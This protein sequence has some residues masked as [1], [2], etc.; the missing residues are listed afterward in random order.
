MFPQCEEDTRKWPQSGD[1]LGI[2]NQVY[3]TNTISCCIKDNHKTK[4]YTSAYEV[5]LYN[6]EIKLGT[7]RDGTLKLGTALIMNKD[8]NHHLHKIL[9][10][11]FLTANET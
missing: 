8:F 5:V 2:Q 11:C 3:L 10:K 7:R 6:E 4:S 1:L 9:E